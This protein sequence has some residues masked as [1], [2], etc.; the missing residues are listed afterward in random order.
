MKQFSFIS[1]ILISW[2]YTLTTIV[3]KYIL[4]YKIIN[5]EIQFPDI[6]NK[7]S[8]KIRY[9][10]TKIKYDKYSLESSEY[11]DNLPSTINIFEFTILSLFEYTIDNLPYK[12]KQLKLDIF[13]NKS[14]NNLPLNLLYL[15]VENDFSRKLNKLPSS[16]YK[17]EYNS[18][19][20]INYLP[21]TVKILQLGHQYRDNTFDFLPEGIEKLIINYQIDYNL[22][23]KYNIT[24]INDLPSSIKEILTYECNK[25]FINKI[26]ENKIKYI[27]EF[28]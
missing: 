4:N 24:L 28:L 25:C 7:D 13:F 14:I 21:S 16:L 6:D 11:I 22:T 19:T 23:K 26:Y 20:P 9:N 17:F 5:Q 10:T 18:Y 2:F 3:K 1:N 12:L 27:K 15:S 8:N